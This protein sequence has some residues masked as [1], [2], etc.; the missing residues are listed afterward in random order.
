MERPYIDLAVATFGQVTYW[1]DRDQMKGRILLRAKY[2]DNE[3]VPRKI[4]LH[5]PL[6]AGGGGESWTISVFLLE[7]Y[8]INMPH[9]EDL[10]PVAS[11]NPDGNG[12]PDDADP[13]DRNI[14]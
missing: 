7:G 11:H 3:S 4:V 9:E 5:D 10:P 14:W 1:L 8:F 6:R 13:D 2:R 12:G